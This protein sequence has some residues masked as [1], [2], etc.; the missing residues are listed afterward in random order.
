MFS[1]LSS[2]R[3]LQ[4]LVDSIEGKISDKGFRLKNKYIIH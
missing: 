2:L 3:F 1:L 4:E